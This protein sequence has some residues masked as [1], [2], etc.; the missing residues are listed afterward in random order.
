VGWGGLGHLLEER[1]GWGGG[2][3]CGA[4]RGWMGGSGNGIWSAKNELQI[5]LNL[6]TMIYSS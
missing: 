4:D 2:M 1:V 6:K 3:G 5:K